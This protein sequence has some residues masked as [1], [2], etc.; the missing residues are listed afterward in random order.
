M[1]DIKEIFDLFERQVQEL[2]DSNFNKALPKS[3]FTFNA[4]AGRSN[5]LNES[6]P[7]YESIKSF[8]L[9]F[10]QFILDEP[11]SIKNIAKAYEE[12]PEDDSLRK[13]FS[14]TRIKFNEF[15][16]SNPPLIMDN[17]R[18]TN[19]ELLDMFLY[20]SFFH[21]NKRKDFEKWVGGGFPGELVYHE[22]IYILGKALKFI[23]YFASINQK[24]LS[25][26]SSKQCPTN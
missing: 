24:Y 5:K 19:H 1:R 20:G 18:T 10:R 13:E 26:E 8:V 25:R 23:V 15:L 12:L 3:K 6:G 9:T 4:I 16:D 17:Q 22:L 14:E 11:I 21:L 7:D 2:C